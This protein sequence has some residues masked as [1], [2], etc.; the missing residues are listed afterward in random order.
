MVAVPLE[1]TVCEVWIKNAFTKLSSTRLN[2]A[3]FH[4]AWRRP[5]AVMR[6]PVPST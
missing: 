3:L 6:E 4:I 2:D 1:S 5:S